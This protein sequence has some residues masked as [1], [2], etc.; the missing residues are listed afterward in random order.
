[1]QPLYTC[2]TSSS[3]NFFYAINHSAHSF[4]V[5]WSGSVLATFIIGYTLSKFL[6]VLSVRPSVCIAGFLE[7]SE[8]LLKALIIGKEVLK[9]TNYLIDVFSYSLSLDADDLFRRRKTLISNG[10]HLSCRHQY[11]TISGPCATGNAKDIV[12][13]NFSRTPCTFKTSLSSHEYRVNLI[14]TLGCLVYFFTKF[15]LLYSCH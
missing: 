3:Y 1:M 8:V 11:T 15:S 12:F 6:S 2:C 13:P 7:Q 9:V 4:V 14:K 5:I 10:E